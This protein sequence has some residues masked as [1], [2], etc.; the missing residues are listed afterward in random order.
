MLFD[1]YAEG[2]TD[3]FGL[4]IGAMGDVDGDGITELFASQISLTNSPK[5]AVF[6]FSGRDGTPALYR[7]RPGEAPRRLRDDGAFPSWIEMVPSPPAPPCT[8]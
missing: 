4:S 3:H 6:V 2:G 7:V 1:F 8:R 5:G